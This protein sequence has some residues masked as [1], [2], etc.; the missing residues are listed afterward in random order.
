MCLCT[1]YI[2]HVSLLQTSLISVT[3][4]FCILHLLAKICAF[5]APTAK[6][7]RNTPGNHKVLDVWVR[8]SFSAPG[9]R[10]KGGKRHRW[11]HTCWK[12]QVLAGLPR[13]CLWVCTQMLIT[14]SVPTVYIPE[15]VQICFRV[16]VSKEPHASAT[17]CLVTSPA[18]PRLPTGHYATRLETPH[19]RS[20]MWNGSVKGWQRKGR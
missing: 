19:G 15:Q 1:P 7:L 5:H 18:K 2:I 9:N 20:V 10:N 14:P 8:K 12:P 17:L 6:F 11:F 13:F 4:T 3:S 16:S